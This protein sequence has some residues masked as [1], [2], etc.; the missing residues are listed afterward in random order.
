MGEKEEEAIVVKALDW[1]IL[2]PLPLA[3]FGFGSLECNS[4]KLCK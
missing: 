4:S 2:S 1:D 3:G